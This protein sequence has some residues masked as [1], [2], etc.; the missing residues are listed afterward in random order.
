RLYEDRH[1]IPCLVHLTAIEAL[2]GEHVEDDSRPVDSIL[3]AW[4]AQ[5]RDAPTM[6]HVG[7]HVAHGGG[8]T[9][10]LQPN[11]EAFLH[12]QLALDVRKGLAANVE[13]ARRAHLP[14]KI[15]PVFV[16]IGDDDVARASE[17]DDGDGH[18]ADWTRA[19]DEHIF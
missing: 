8:D 15:E 9:G 5:Q 10:H 13:R 7:E 18:Q 19:S 3:C 1:L 12:P 2:D 14:G 16:D 6:R 4:Q 11:I 17:T